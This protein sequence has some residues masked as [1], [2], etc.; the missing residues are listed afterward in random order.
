MQIK[1]I[2]L[3]AAGAISVFGVAG[4]A[5]MQSGPKEMTFFVK[6]LKQVSLI[7]EKTF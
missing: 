7:T 2:W 3:A 6:C 1:T 5:S 4:C